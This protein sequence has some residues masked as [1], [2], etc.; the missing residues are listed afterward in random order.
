MSTYHWRGELDKNIEVTGSNVDIGDTVA[1]IDVSGSNGG[2]F[3]TVDAISTWHSLAVITLQVNEYVKYRTIGML[4]YYYQHLP[5]GPFSIYITNSPNKTESLTYGAEAGST[6]QRI[7]WDATLPN[8]AVVKLFFKRNTINDCKVYVNGGLQ[9]AHS[10]NSCNNLDD[11][12]IGVNVQ[13]GPGLGQSLTYI[14]GIELFNLPQYVIDIDDWDLEPGDAIDVPDCYTLD[15]YLSS[16]LID[17]NIETK[18]EL[19]PQGLIKEWINKDIPNLIMMLGA[20]LNQYYR[21]F[22]TVALDSCKASQHTGISHASGSTSVTGFTGLTVNDYQGG[23]IGVVKGDVYYYAKIES[24]TA[25][26]VTITNGSD[27][28]VLS[29]DTVVLD[30]IN[31]G[32]YA[33]IGSI[34]KMNFDDAIWAVLDGNGKPIAKLPIEFVYNVQNISE[35]DNNVYWYYYNNKIYFASGSGGKISGHIMIGYY[36]MPVAVSSLSD[37]IDLPF[38]Y[39]T[40][41]QKLTQ[42]RILQRLGKEDKSASTLKEVLND[43][44]TIIGSDETIKLFDKLTGEV[45]G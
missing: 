41:A 8:L 5:C 35:F 24:N 10:G 11:S 40:M 33:D 44:K 36:K 45:D 9:A 17:S 37:C 31:T 22:A 13:N 3:E 20:Q 30:V 32:V 14:Y 15:E 42:V 38:E 27:I 23:C 2:S 4:P 21:R 25:T 16:L 18:V 7:E 43:V 19:F 1:T 39:C 12:T 34:S 29:S 26:T 28:P 6:W